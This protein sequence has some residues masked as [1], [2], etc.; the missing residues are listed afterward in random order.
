M[1]LIKKYQLFLESVVPDKLTYKN[2]NIVSELTTSMTIINPNFLDKLLDSGLK[3]RYTENSEIY[4]SDLKSLLMNKNNRLKLGKFNEDVNCVEDTETSRVNSVFSGVEFSI[5]ED[6]NK[7][8]NARITARNIV[9]KILGGDEKLTDEMLKNVYWLGPNKTKEFSEDIVIELEDGRQLSVY[10]N[11][12]LNLSKS[13]SFNTLADDIMGDNIENIFS[14]D[15]ISKWNKLTQ[16]WCRIIYENAN[17]NIQR[18]IERFIDPTRIESIGYFEYFD[19]KHSDPRYKHLGELFKE[20]NKNITDF[21]DLMSEIWNHREICFIDPDRVTKEWLERKI[22]ILNSKI[23]EHILTD[24][25]KKTSES[26]IERLPDG[27]KLADGNLKMK[28]IKT[29]V[30]KMGCL[31]RDIYYLGNNGN[32]FYR[33]PSRQFFRDNYEDISIKFDYHVKMVLDEGEEENNDFKIKVKMELDG[34]KFIDLIINVNFGSKE[35]SGK[36]SAK[37]KFDLAD[38]F[39]YIVSEKGKSF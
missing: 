1:K 19:V 31:E 16:E 30:E 17:K 35:M 24:S 7:L 12:N 28:F 39:N 3:A 34:D 21:S 27:M 14:N 23:L 29:I 26:E 20:F 2:N 15:Y 37:Y 9:D 10:L 38:T 5:E 32:V 22:F 8:I 36:L 18:Y 33:V 4:V 11:K 13:A 6:W 25:I